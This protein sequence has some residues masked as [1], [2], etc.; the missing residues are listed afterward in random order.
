MVVSIPDAWFQCSAKFWPHLDADP[1]RVLT[2]LR[3]AVGKDDAAQQLLDH[4]ISGGQQSFRHLD[5]E[6]LG[7]LQV[8]DEL[9]LARLNDRQV[10]G[11]NTLKDL[12]V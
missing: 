2:Q 10:D 4:L 1:R 7:G 6:Q 8:D 3:H 12:P 5:A 11:L 9:E